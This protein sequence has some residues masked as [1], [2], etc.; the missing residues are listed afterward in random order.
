MDADAQA[1]ARESAESITSC[2]WCRKRP[3][4]VG[5][6]VESPET[7]TGKAY[8]CEECAKLCLSI[9]D[10]ER[11]RRTGRFPDDHGASS[12]TRGST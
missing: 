12:S 6:L 5:P 11:W 10:I 3:D 9:F 1:S 4:E 2:S 8:I 7:G